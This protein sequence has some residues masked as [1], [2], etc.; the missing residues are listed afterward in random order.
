MDE[1]YITRKTDEKEIRLS[2]TKPKDDCYVRFI[3]DLK[4]LLDKYEYC[5]EE[6]VVEKEPI[7]CDSYCKEEHCI[8]STGE[9][10]E[11]VEICNGTREIDECSCGGDKRKCS[12]YK[13]D[14]K[15]GK[16]I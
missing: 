15:T 8:P 4:V 5:F 13:Y 6:K 7:P 12:F 9:Y 14:D 1:I 3:H 11:T 16:L 10:V 2:W